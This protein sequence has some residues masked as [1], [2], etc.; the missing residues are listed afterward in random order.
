MPS[1]TSFIRMVEL[2][3]VPGNQNITTKQLVEML[4]RNIKRT[5]LLVILISLSLLGSAQVRIVTGR[6]ID[7]YDRS[8]IS[9]L[10]VYV[11]G[12]ISSVVAVTDENGYY[13]INV[14]PNSTLVFSIVG[15]TTQEIPVADRAI[16]NAELDCVACDFQTPIGYRTSA[17]DFSI[18]GTYAFN[19]WGYGFEYAYIPALSNLSYK[20]LKYTDLNIRMQ[21]FPHS[22]NN[23]RFFPHLRISIPLPIPL[24]TTHQKL[25]P[26]I[27]AG[28]YFD[29][30]FKTIPQHNWA[31]GGGVKTRLAHISFGRRFMNIHLTAGY[32]V[33]PK[34]E[35]KDNM[36]VGLKFYMG[37][38]IFIE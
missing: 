35:K 17:H 3:N 29:T 26:Y 5:T 25:H 6:V 28:Y 34:A 2:K 7:K 31:I 21:S 14:N 19:D 38:I 8:P 10:S 12:S 20:T 22:N 11:K 27:N 4:K 24:F 30:D 15:Y 9:Y 36:Y 23:L 37:R 33:Y 13:S 18:L 32:T 16:I 1:T